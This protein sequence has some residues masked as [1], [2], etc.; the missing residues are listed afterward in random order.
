MK[1]CIVNR[2]FREKKD[3]AVKQ[4]QVSEKK[5]TEK[6]V[7]EF[8]KILKEDYYELYFDGC[9]KGNPGCAGAGFA[10]YKNKEEIE[11]RASFVG[12]RET[13]NTAE[14][15]GLI[16]GLDEALKHN[17]KILHVK[18]DSMLVIKQMRGEY[19]VKAENMIF[20]FNQA[21]NLEKC[22]DKIHYTHVYREFNKRADELSNIGLEYAGVETLY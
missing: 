12:K 7:E 20:L 17:I 2:M 3:V 10:I 9:S 6:K 22:F 18:G 11:A 15:T 13:N 1:Q 5:V 16:L 19:K 8:D 21:K 4:E 14:Y